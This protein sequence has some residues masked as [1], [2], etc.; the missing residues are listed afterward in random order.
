MK[1]GSRRWCLAISRVCPRF[2]KRRHDVNIRKWI[3]RGADAMDAPYEQRDGSH[4][5]FDAAWAIAGFIVRRD[6]WQMQSIGSVLKVAC[7]PVF[8]E[9]PWWLKSQSQPLVK[10][11][12]SIAER[13][14]LKAH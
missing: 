8:K 2:D 3:P 10:T 13:D 6:A 5:A 11:P 14:G 9:V 12:N 7:I 1:F 4:Q